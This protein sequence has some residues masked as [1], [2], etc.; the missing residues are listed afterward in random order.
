MQSERS[1][2]RSL[3]R[4]GCAHRRCLRDRWRRRRR[5]GHPRRRHR[6]VGRAAIRGWSGFSRTRNER[7]IDADRCRLHPHREDL[8]RT[9]R[10]PPDN[11]A[12][13]ACGSPM[14]TPIR[15]L[16]ATG[17]LCEQCSSR[18]D[19]PASKLPGSRGAPLRTCPGCERLTCRRCWPT[20]TRKC[21]DCRDRTGRR[22][23]APLAVAI[24]HPVERRTP[25]PMG[26]PRAMVVSGPA[27]VARTS[28]EPPTFAPGL[29]EHRGP[30]A[31]PPTR[32]PD[33]VAPGPVARVAIDPPFRLPAKTLKPRR[34][35]A[36]SA[37]AD[38]GLIRAQPLSTVTPAREAR[39]SSGIGTRRRPR[40]AWGPVAL[41][42]AG[43][44][45]LTLLLL[46]PSAPPRGLGSGTGQPIG[47]GSGAENGPARVPASPAP[48]IRAG[49]SF[50]PASERSVSPTAP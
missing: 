35:V 49:S 40:V 21:V 11:G 47:G 27:P 43:I 31:P 8:A 3:A 39:R 25:T 19:V 48:T 13:A 17:L 24:P 12:G 45:M 5:P 37:V 30:V 41:F 34:W 38:L 36:T 32:P 2:N 18:F 16:K 1:S 20:G 46:L 26:P 28:A 4:T 7:R 23:S 9:H 50:E 33:P 22:A 44:S 15:N 10:A 42:A 29:A 14:S 6:I